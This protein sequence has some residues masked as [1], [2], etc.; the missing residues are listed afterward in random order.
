MR[1]ITGK[2]DSLVYLVVG[3]P[4]C[5]L[6]MLFWFVW[7]FFLTDTTV[8]GFEW[9]AFWERS[10]MFFGLAFSSLF[11]FLILFCVSLGRVSNE[12]V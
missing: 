8:A 4:V 6:A 5:L 1:F 9:S 3:F 11:P 7:A 10:L 2:L 12:R